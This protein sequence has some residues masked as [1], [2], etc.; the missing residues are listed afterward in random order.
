MLTSSETSLNELRDELSSIISVV[1]LSLN[2]LTKFYRSI[3]WSELQREIDALQ[4]P[5]SFS[6]TSSL[7]EYQRRIVEQLTPRVVKHFM[8][9]PDE[10]NK[11]VY[12]LHHE[13]QQLTKTLLATEQ[14]LVESQSRHRIAEEELRERLAAFEMQAS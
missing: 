7:I 8:R 3:E 13:N 2:S 12:R 14:Q 6:S 11:L 10:M 4:E 9:N 1:C 5:L